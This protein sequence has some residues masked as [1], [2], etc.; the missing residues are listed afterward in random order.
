MPEARSEGPPAA[1]G[2]LLPGE[3]HTKQEHVVGFVVAMDVVGAHVRPSEI[4]PLKREPD[5]QL[6]AVFVEC[7]DSDRQ[8]AIDRER[9]RS[10]AVLERRAVVAKALICN[11]TVRAFTF[12]PGVSGPNPSAASS[13]G[14]HRGANFVNECPGMLVSTGDA[15]ISSAVAPRA[16]CAK[17]GVMTSLAVACQARA[18]NRHRSLG[19]NDIGEA[20]A[21]KLVWCEPHH[22]REE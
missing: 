13:L 1:P 4:C 9:R 8:L 12:P 18:A 21:S 14:A 6:L 2:E 15:P 22:W 16:R 5:A 17:T 10:V 7:P 3:S 11:A 20:F 19:L